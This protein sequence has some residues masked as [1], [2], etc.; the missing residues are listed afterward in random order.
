MRE[1]NTKDLIKLK[2][3]NPIL[4]RIV[5]RAISISAVDF[6]IVQGL[7][8]D[9]EQWRLVL[10]GKSQT[11]QSRH[12]TGDAVDVAAMIGDGN[13]RR[14]SWDS[15]LYPVIAKAFAQA[16]AEAKEDI[17]WGGCWQVLPPGADT[18]AIRRMLDQYAD[19]CRAKNKKPFCDLGHFEIPRV[20]Q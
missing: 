3:V 1:P 7:R 8:E 17:R 15:V 2:G 10:A 11:L 13:N 9:A 5:L 6:I 16:A 12:L 20:L 19:A 4:Q 14:L 18:P